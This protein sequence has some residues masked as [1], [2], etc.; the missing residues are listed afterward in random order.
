MYHLERLLFGIILLSSFGSAFADEYVPKPD[1][2]DQLINVL[3]P[4]MIIFLFDMKEEKERTKKIEERM[5]KIEKRI[6]TKASEEIEVIEENSKRISIGEK[7]SIGMKV[8]IRRAF[9]DFLFLL[10]LFILP[11][12]VFYKNHEQFATPLW[13]PILFGATAV[14]VFTIF[15][16]NYTLHE[17]ELLVY[18]RLFSNLYFPHSN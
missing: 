10:S 3:V 4:T 9:D 11:S 16:V 2:F 7:K 12:I 8:K 17:N 15:I 6:S 1:I 13:I 18:S 14:F 5:E